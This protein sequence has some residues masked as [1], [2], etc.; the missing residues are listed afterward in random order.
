MNPPNAERACDA[1]DA[2]RAPARA[3]L[4]LVSYTHTGVMHRQA[5]FTATARA[6]ARA[7]LMPVPSVHKQCSRL[8]RALAR[9]A[10]GHHA[11]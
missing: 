7:M 10:H 8:C 6:R 9:G 11:C 2:A 1:C 3:M 5:V 4:R